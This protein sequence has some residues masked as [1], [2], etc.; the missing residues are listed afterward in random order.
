MIN[1][2]ITR[3]FDDT[4]YP[5]TYSTT[6]IQNEYVRIDEFNVNSTNS[7]RLKFDLEIEASSG[8]YYAQVNYTRIP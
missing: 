8:Q 3:C 4:V 2:A 5:S 1:Y 6:Q 7:D